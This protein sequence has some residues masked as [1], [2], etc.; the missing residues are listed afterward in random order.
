[1]KHVVVTGANKGIGLAIVKRLLKEYPDV[2]VFLGSRDCGRGKAAIEQIAME[3]GESIKSRVELLELDVISDESV[4]K[5]IET[6]KKNLGGSANLL[7][8]LVNN[9][10]GGGLGGENP[11]KQTVE[12]NMYSVRRVSEAFLPL[13]Q[14]KGRIVQVSSG[15]APMF[16]QKCSEDIKELLS[17][18]QDVTWNDIETKVIQ[19]ALYISEDATLT[20]EEKASKVAEKGLGEMGGMYFYGLAKACVNAYTLFLSNQNPSIHMNSCSPG[21]IETDLTRP[22]SEKSGRTPSEMGMLPVEKGTIAPIHLLMDDLEGN[23]RYYGSDAKRS[24]M[25]RTRSPGDPVYD[26]VFP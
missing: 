15:A 14:T 9:A 19:P 18:K 10:G 7:Y 17:N 8:G 13:I 1:M 25:H 12:L 11:G 5:A 22:F 26:V 23:G 24:P 2:H 16:L 20:E 21:F 4:Q 6:V 3:M